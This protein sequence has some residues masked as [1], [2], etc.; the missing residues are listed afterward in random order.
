MTATQI[1]ASIRVLLVAI[2]AITNPRTNILHV[3]S[4]NC[5]DQAGLNAKNELKVVQ[6]K[7]SASRTMIEWRG[8]R[9]GSFEIPHEKMVTNAIMRL[10]GRDCEKPNA[11]R[12]G[13]IRENHS[14][15]R[16]P[17]KG[18]RNVNPSPSDT[19]ATSQMSRIG[20]AAV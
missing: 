4:Q 15:I 5:H 18:K 17:T 14:Q 13:F 11:S 1:S 20:R 7:N 2:P 19:H 12:C 8:I 9:L 10:R 16:T 6:I 3:R